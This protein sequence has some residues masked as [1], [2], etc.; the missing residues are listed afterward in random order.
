MAAWRGVSPPC[1][2]CSRVEGQRVAMYLTSGML[3]VM[4]AQWRQVSPSSFWEWMSARAS[5]TRNLR[6]CLCPA[7]AA[8]CAGVKLWQ[9]VGLTMQ[10]PSS[11]STRQALTWPV[12][13]ARCRGVLPSSFCASTSALPSIRHLTV[14]GS[15][16]NA[17]M[18]SAVKPSESLHSRSNP[19]SSL[20]H[21]KSESLMPAV[22]PTRTM[23]I[24]RLKTASWYSFLSLRQTLLVR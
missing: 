21:A 8:R 17:A 7:Y 16:A 6:M 20:R 24:M 22:S 18:W 1:A 2:C 12:I 10:P 15:P 14:S 19:Q 11:T 5:S 4:T 23:S 9:F 13:A 3:Q